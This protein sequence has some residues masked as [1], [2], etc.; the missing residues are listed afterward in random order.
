[1]LINSGATSL[2]S[3]VGR[4]ESS[5]GQ[6]TAAIAALSCQISALS[7]PDRVAEQA[8]RLGLQPAQRVYYVQ[9]GAPVT[10]GETTVAGR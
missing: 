4:S 10:E 9:S 7:A 6:L 2:E 3:E 8:A 5:Q 1:M